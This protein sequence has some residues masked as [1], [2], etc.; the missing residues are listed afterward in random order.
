VWIDGQPLTPPEA[1][2]GIEYLSK[3]EYWPLELWG[4]AEKPAK[5][6]ADE[7]FVLGDFSAASK[8][9]RLWQKGASGHSPYAVPASY[10]IGVVT[11]IY[12][13]PSRWRI[14]R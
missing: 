6:G 5:L 9:S 7:Y 10:M 14:I 8:D 4:T 1:I 13:P 2:R 12:W 11:H 3:L